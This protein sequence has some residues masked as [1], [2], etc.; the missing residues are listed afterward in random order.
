MPARLD[1]R[2]SETVEI[3]GVPV[4]VG[5]ARGRKCVLYVATYDADGLIESPDDVKRAATRLLGSV[6]TP[7]WSKRLDGDE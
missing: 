7:G 1:L 4:A 6:L 5:L 3:G 2:E